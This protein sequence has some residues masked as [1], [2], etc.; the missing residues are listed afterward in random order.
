LLI[1]IMENIS[2]HYKFLSSVGNQ[3]FYHKYVTYTNSSGYT[4]YA[5]GGPTASP[6][7]NP[8][9]NLTNAQANPSSWSGS[10]P[11]G[12]IGTESGEY[13]PG[14][15]DWDD[16]GDDPSEII[17]SG[18]D[19]SGEWN[20]IK[21]SFDDIAKEKWA[22]RPI[23]QNSNTTVDEA[24]NRSGLPLPKKSGWDD[25]WSPG[26]GA[27]LPAPTEWSITDPFTG[28]PLDTNPYPLDPLINDLFTQG[29]NW[30]P[31]G[32]DP[33]VLD[34]DG[35]GIETVGIDPN[36]PLLFDVDGSGTKTATGWVKADDGL[37]V[38][39]RNN[40]GTIDSGQ[41]LFGDAT[42]T[43]ANSPFKDGFTALAK[44]DQNQDGKINSQD[45]VFSK[46]RVWQDLNQDGISQAAELKTLAQLG[47][48]SISVQAK[49]ETLP[50]GN[51]NTISHTATY[52]K[53]DGTIGQAATV[54]TSANLQLANNP[55]YRQFTDDP[56]IT[57]AAQNLPQ[58]GGSGWVRDLRQAMSLGTPQASALQ[59]KVAAYSQAT[60]VQSSANAC[61]WQLAA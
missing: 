38:L 49:N 48:A 47:I 35:D 41:E 4:F 44:E 40:N 58:T 17:K 29:K 7:G 36:K 54:Q 22:Y 12:D 42:P 59:T 30:R 52:T 26:S 9:S 19:L 10:S 25:N 31:A 56:A 28:L 53:T 6:P 23:S 32:R 43:V 15:I 51:G 21:K 46:L 57:T 61:T 39:D 16:E 8:L 14:T 37:L 1:E 2:V 27:D 20:N 34:L 24:L 3:S 45:A 55:F 33:L 13:I 11:F 18:E 50:Q 60:T 5:R